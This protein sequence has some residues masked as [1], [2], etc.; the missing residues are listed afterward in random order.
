MNP[1]FSL[2]RISATNQNAPLGSQRFHWHGL[3]GILIGLALIFHQQSELLPGWWFGLLGAFFLGLAGLIW[4]CIRRLLASRFNFRR[5]ISALL[6]SGICLIAWSSWTNQAQQRLDDRLSAQ[7]EGREIQVTGLIASMPQEKQFSQRF[8]FLVSNSNAATPIHLPKKIVLSW[9]PDFKTDS[10]QYLA[11]GQLWMFTVKLKRPVGAINFEGFD[12]ELNVFRQGIGAFGSVQKNEAQFLCTVWCKPFWDSGL[13]PSL[14]TIALERLRLLVSQSLDELTPLSGDRATGVIKALAIG[15]QSAITAS[16]WRLFNRTGVS[17]LMSISGMHVT[18]TASMAAWCAVLL[19]NRIAARLSLPN[20]ARLPNRRRLAW[21]FAIVVALLYCALAGWG[22]PAQR[23]VF[24]VVF[25]GLLAHHRSGLSALWVLQ[26]VAFC[27]L[28]LDPWAVLTVG[29][30]LSFLAVAG[31]M[32]H[33]NSPDHLK[34]DQLH[35]Q[36]KIEPESLIEKTPRRLIIE[37]FFKHTL[38]QALRAQWACTWVLLPALAYFFG[39]ISL[40]SVIANALAIPVI[41]LIITPLALASAVLALF[42]PGFAISLATGLVQVISWMLN[43]LFAFLLWLDQSVAAQW[44]VGQPT[45][46]LTVVATLVIML[47]LTRSW[48]PFFRPSRWHYPLKSLLLSFSILCLVLP[49]VSQSTVKNAWSVTFFDVGQ[50]SAIL[51]RSGDSVVLFD[52]GPQQS[53]E[54]DAGSNTIVPALRLLG[55]RKIDLLVL[56]HLDTAHIGGLN[57][58]LD[59]MPIEKIWTALPENSVALQRIATLGANRVPDRCQ[60]GLN[61]VLGNL[62][63]E[64]LHPPKIEDTGG[65]A[66]DGPTN[67]AANSQIRRPA[68]KTNN[69][70]SSCVLMIRSGQHKVLLTADI[71]N[72][73]ERWLVQQYGEALNA[74]VLAMP[75]QGAASGSSSLFLQTVRP[76]FAVSQAGYRNRWQTPNKVLPRYQELGIKVERTDQQGAVRFQFG[77]VQ[78]HGFTGISPRIRSES[79]GQITVQTARHERDAYW[80]IK[81]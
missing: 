81:P 24:T 14:P 79:S 78:P 46:L 32:L 61:T 74:D 8:E 60:S 76:Q 38:V 28:V 80:R 64:A 58:I 17:H 21:G 45:L 77:A 41:G 42:L 43:L 65:G 72:K 40:V 68:K 44:I 67:E 39:S 59:A 51:I 53:A 18:M 26:A 37:H 63:L 15:E 20:A 5:L 35:L 29:F 7:S 31:L 48:L 49:T 11:P 71:E 6:L 4:F 56:S 16:D 27:I 36:P 54:S 10:V 57:A 70:A 13:W 30:W 66:A 1:A 23:T 2:S 3:G 25:I 75:G 12:S 69:N 34:V 22:I 9:A 55:I 62:V 19:W 47:A 52:A 73:Q 33:G 50:G